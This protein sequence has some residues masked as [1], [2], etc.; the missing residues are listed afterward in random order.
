MIY[1]LA[2]LITREIAPLFLEHDDGRP[3]FPEDAQLMR[4]LLPITNKD[5]AGA[6][7]AVVKGI[8]GR[9]NRYRNGTF[10]PVLKLCFWLCIVASAIEDEQACVGTYGALDVLDLA[11]EINLEI[12]GDLEAKLKELA[13]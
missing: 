12:P 10:A 3:C 8:S 11:K 7:S 9:I 5:R 4:R 6:A 13:A 1:P 2:D